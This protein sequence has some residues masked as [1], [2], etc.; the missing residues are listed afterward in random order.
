M[1]CNFGIY[2]NYRKNLSVKFSFRAVYIYHSRYFQIADGI[3]TNF[4]NI[5]ALL[6]MNFPVIATDC[7]AS[8]I[9]FLST[10]H[11]VNLETTC[12]LRASRIAIYIS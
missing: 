7:Y 8:L 12:N 5:L 11:T 3:W 9:M 1:Y 10:C 2:R 4:E 6:T